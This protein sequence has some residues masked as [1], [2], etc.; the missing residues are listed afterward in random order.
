MHMY[1]YMYMYI[2]IPAMHKSARAQVLEG[3]L[4]TGI[5]TPLFVILWPHRH[6]PH[7]TCQF[8][9]SPVVQSQMICLCFRFVYQS[10]LATCH[11]LDGQI[12]MKFPCNNSILSPTVIPMS[13]PY[14]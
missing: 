10:L 1:M 2:H 14:S 7:E 13:I 12:L 5:Q 9:V 11:I 4:A 6:S 8:K 3:S